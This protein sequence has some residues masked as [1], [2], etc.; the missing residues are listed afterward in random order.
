MNKNI[1]KGKNTA[2]FD[3][4]GTIVETKPI[5]LRALRQILEENSLSFVNEEDYFI[6]GG[7]DWKDIWEAIK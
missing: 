1:F 3:L 5:V 4:D 2:L 7:R 6:T